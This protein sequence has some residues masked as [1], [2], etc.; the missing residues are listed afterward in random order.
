MLKKKIKLPLL[1]FAVVVMMSV[2]YI[3]ESKQPTTPVN[4]GGELNEVSLNPEYANA[5][6]ENI[7]NVNLLIE[8][9]EKL[10]SSGTLSVTEVNQ[11]NNE[12][13]ELKETKLNEVALEQMLIDALSFVDVLVVFEEDYLVIDVYTSNELTNEMFISVSRLAKEK[14]DSNYKVK[15]IKTPIED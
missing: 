10:I 12:I 5:R 9:K 1:I 7:Q 3:H 11:I 2:F 14:F 8:E 15:V 13:N 6:L 4:G